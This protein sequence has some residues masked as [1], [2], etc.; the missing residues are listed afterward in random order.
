[1]VTKSQQQMNST[2][3]PKRKGMMMMKVMQAFHLMH[4][5]LVLG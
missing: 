2:N 3:T 1:M 4:L 5:A